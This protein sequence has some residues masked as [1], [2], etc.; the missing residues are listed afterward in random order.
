MGDDL[1]L[2]T[3]M[4]GGQDL[5]RWRPGSPTVQ[6]FVVSEGIVLGGEWDARARRFLYSSGGRLWAAGPEGGIGT[7]L[8][9]D[10]AGTIECASLGGCVKGQR[11]GA[12]YVFYSI[13][14]ASGEQTE[15][16]RIDFRPPF[17]NF[18]VSPDGSTVAVVHN[19][20]DVIRFVDL[21][22]G[23]ERSLEV[24][25]WAHFEFVS[26]S[27][28]GQR[29]FVNAGYASSGG[30]PVLLAVELDGSASLLRRAANVWHVMPTASPSGRYLA[31]ATMPFQGNAYLLTD[32]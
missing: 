24:A 30:Y 21:T 13:D 14:A 16:A 5:Y 4:A 2:V 10:G 23:E 11:Q 28:D 8:R 25:G 3:A 7:Q 6:P 29:L 1:I 22:S 9:E 32:F 31:F 26:W 17:A 15:L 20:D 19:N 18:A 12:D 27:V